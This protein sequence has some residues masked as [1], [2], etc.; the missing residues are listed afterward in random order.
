M[1]LLIA[2]AGA[3]GGLL[4]TDTRAMMDGRP[5]TTPWKIA[6]SARRGSWSAVR[7]L[8]ARR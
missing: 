5:L 1:T 2:V 7:L 3:R 8:V 4:A 6:R